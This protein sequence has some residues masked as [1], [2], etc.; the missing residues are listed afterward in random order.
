MKKYIFMLVLLLVLGTSVNATYQESEYYYLLGT[1]DAAFLPETIFANDI[2]TM[3]IDVENRGVYYSISDLNATIDLGNEFTP[4]DINPFI[5][6]IRQE[7]TKTIIFKFKVND[8]V[9]P[10]YYPVTV[11]F[12][13]V[14]DGYPRFGETEKRKEV[15]TFY[16]PITKSEK[17]LDITVT[18]GVV[19]PGS[20]ETLKFTVTNLTNQPISN[21]SFSWRE[22]ND[23]VLPLGSDNKRFISFI[24]PRESKSIE[25]LVTADPN[26]ITGIY[27]L[28]AITTLQ[29][30]TGLISQESTLGLIVGGTTDF[31]ISVDLSETLF[32]VNIANIGT[33]NA[34]SVVIK[35]V[36]NEITA[37]NKTEIIGNLNRGD[38]TIASFEITNVN[39]DK[40]NLEINYTDTT[41]E[42]QVITKTILLSKNSTE[43]S[44][45]LKKG[46]KQSPFP[47]TELIILIGLL[48]TGTIVYKK[49]NFIK[50]KIKKIKK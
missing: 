49:R 9:V 25:Y 35:L 12:N 26:I 14:G 11:T 23:L 29:D 20:K 34:E 50:E 38:Y 19:S 15:R 18:P 43:N 32:S 22:K 10:G 1:T 28:T 16:V 7:S 36:S 4:I 39:T 8:N 45:E 27:P 37:K 44:N 41:G 48:L 42:R 24:G 21:I 31:E 46:N 47:T 3:A 13:Y 33:N 17:K 5:E 2:V 30:S 6:L 40:T